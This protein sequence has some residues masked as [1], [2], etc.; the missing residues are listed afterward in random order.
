MNWIRLAGWIGPIVGGGGGLLGA[1]IGAYF[2]IKNT[3]GPRERAFVIKACILCWVFVALFIAGL[4]LIPSWYKLLLVI[5]Y[6]VVGC[7]GLRKW[8]EIQF[9]IRKE[10][11]GLDT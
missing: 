7:F 5:P 11:S 2:A 8:N 10:E 1:G 9:R 3:Q 4:C 6:V